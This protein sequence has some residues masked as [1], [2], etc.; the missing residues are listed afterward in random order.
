M[1]WLEVMNNELERMWKEA[2]VAQSEILLRS[3]RRGTEEKPRPSLCQ[4][5]R[6][7]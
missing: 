3:L 6:C 5:S 2:A 4:I 1:G 7:P